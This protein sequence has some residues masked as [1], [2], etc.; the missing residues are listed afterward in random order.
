MKFSCSFSNLFQNI[1]VHETSNAIRKIKKERKNIFKK[2]KKNSVDP[3]HF[4][5]FI[6]KTGEVKRKFSSLKKIAFLEK[7]KQDVPSYE[8]TLLFPTL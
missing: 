6:D 7:D 5:L 8:N 4:I 3:G 2:F 1:S